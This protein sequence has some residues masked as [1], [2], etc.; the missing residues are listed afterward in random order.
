LATKYGIHW[1]RACV[2]E[3]EWDRERKRERVNSIFVNICVK[4]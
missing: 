2:C 3:C 4:I 1:L